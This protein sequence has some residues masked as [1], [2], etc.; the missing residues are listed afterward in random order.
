MSDEYILDLKNIICAKEISPV[1]ADEIIAEISALW[2]GVNLYL[3]KNHA[4][5]IRRSHVKIYNE[6]QNGAE[7]NELAIRHDLSAA[8]IYKIINE[9]KSKN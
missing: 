7:V 4:E 8:R 6:F 1:I 9:Q 2:R 3:K 5:K